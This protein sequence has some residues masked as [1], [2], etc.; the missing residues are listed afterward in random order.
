MLC[1]MVR[2]F[3]NQHPGSARQAFSQPNAI[4]SDYQQ[5]TGYTTCH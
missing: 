4:A 2:V 3:T 5:K 1:A